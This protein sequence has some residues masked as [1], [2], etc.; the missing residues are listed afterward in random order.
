MPIPES[1]LSTSSIILEHDG[2]SV[3]AFAGAVRSITGRGL[4]HLLR[5]QLILRIDEGP[6]VE[7]TVSA[8]D[9]DHTLGPTRP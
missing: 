7:V 5:Q 9:G 6:A 4:D 1:R 2:A 3:I 8:L